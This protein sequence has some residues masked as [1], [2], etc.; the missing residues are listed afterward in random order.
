ML[1]VDWSWLLV[2]VRAMLE[3]VVELGPVDGL[4][5]QEEL[6]DPVSEEGVAV[7]AIFA[8]FWHSPSK[9][10]NGYE[11]LRHT[12]MGVG[13]QAIQFSGHCWHEV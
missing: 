3:V 10:K 2:R 9:R 7:S 12:M 13:L 5:V 1:T 8:L 4:R 6:L 11:Q